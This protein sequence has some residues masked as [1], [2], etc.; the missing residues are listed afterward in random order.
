MK[1]ALFCGSTLFI[2]TL[3]SCSLVN[4]VIDVPCGFVRNECSS[5]IGCVKYTVMPSGTASVLQVPVM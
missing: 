1:A 3:Q 4:A 2:Y 5:V